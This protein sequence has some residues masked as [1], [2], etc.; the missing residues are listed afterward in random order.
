[1]I[2]SLP[3]SAAP[4]VSRAVRCE[5]TG[6]HSIPL[7]H[8]RA[9]AL[10]ISSSAP[11]PRALKHTKMAEPTAIMMATP[12]VTMMATP[13][14]CII[15]PT[16]TYASHSPMAAQSCPRPPLVASIL[17]C[18]RRIESSRN[19]GVT[20]F[21]VCAGMRMPPPVSLLWAQVRT[22]HRATSA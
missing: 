20:P 8:T 1:M 15:L 9:Q 7:G 6:I 16:T 12:S 18:L 3:T 5:S 21:W 17:H 19:D 13:S 2:S 4:V 10:V 11:C 14:S 22:C